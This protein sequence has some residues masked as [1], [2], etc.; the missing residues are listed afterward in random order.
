M[1]GFRPVK[2][3]DDATLVYEC[4]Y[5]IDVDPCQNDEHE[6]DKREGDPGSDHSTKQSVDR[7][8]E[9]AALGKRRCGATYKPNEKADHNDERNEGDDRGE[10]DRKARRIK[11]AVK[12]RLQT[13]QTF[14]RITE[15]DAVGRREYDRDHRADDLREATRKA[16]GNASQ[17]AD[18][19]DYKKSDV[20]RPSVGSE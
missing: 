18:H 10:N 3:T 4:D 19:Y 1:E 2:R 11:S 15:R 8:Q 14:K 7:A 6:K 17:N 20:D 16:N 5:A 13:E 12:R 9:A